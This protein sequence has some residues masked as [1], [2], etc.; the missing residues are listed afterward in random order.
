[1]TPQACQQ[2]RSNL[3]VIDRFAAAYAQ[4][5][6]A[7]IQ[8]LNTAPTPQT[9]QRGLRLCVEAANMLLTTQEYLATALREL[10]H[11]DPRPTVTLA[12]SI[13]AKRS[14]A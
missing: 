11:P 9:E 13:H 5:F 8:E 14:A 4:R 7:L 12:A 3:D 2:L 10:A 6:A 1:M